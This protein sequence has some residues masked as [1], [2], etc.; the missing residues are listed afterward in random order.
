[1]TNLSAIAVR[2]ARDK[3]QA[4]KSKIKRGELD[5]LTPD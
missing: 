5:I 3:K 4:P 2:V 1:M